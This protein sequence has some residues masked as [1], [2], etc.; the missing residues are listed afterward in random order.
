MAAERWDLECFD[1]YVRKSQAR[2]WVVYDALRQG[3]FLPWDYQ[4]IQDATR[5]YMRND[6]DLNVVESDARFP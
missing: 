3:Q 2:R 4:P 1:A 6:M 5:R